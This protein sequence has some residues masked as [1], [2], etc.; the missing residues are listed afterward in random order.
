MNKNLKPIFTIK[1]ATGKEQ[2]YIADD[3]GQLIP[4]VEVIEKKS[5]WQAVNS[6]ADACKILKLS[7]NTLMLLIQSGQLKAIKA[8]VKRWIVTGQAIEDFLG[9][10]N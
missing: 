7:R 8:G 3:S 2:R 6:I 10:S 1:D 5:P 9:Q 4:L